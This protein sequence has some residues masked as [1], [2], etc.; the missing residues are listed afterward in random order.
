MFRTSLVTVLLIPALAGAK[1]WKPHPIHVVPG[2][3]LKADDIKPYVPPK[4][5]PEPTPEPSDVKVIE[6]V[7]PD[8]VVSIRPWSSPMVGT[9]GQGTRVP[10]RGTVK[11]VKGNGCAKLWYAL[12]PFGYI[13]NRDVKPTD[14][15]ASTEQVLKVREGTRLPF[16]YVMILVKDD[17]FMPMWA[18]LDDLKKGAEPER[19]LKKGDTVAVDKLYKWDGEDYWIAVDGKVIKKQ[20]ASLM[21]GGSSWH[22]IDITDQT[23][24][25]FGW[26]TPDKANVYDAP[27]DKGAKPLK[28]V[29]LERRTRVSIVGE[30]MVGKKLFL[31]VTVAAPPPPPTFGEIF[32]DAEK[33]R[34]AATA[35]TATAT[36]AAA[37]PPPAPPAEMWVSADAVNEVRVLEHPKTVP[38][39]M[40]RWI[41][42][43][44]GEQVLVLY[45]NDKPVWAT[46]TSS[47]RAIPTPM[48]TYPV[49][50]KVA[51]ITMKNQP[52]EDKPYYVNKV[53][54][55]TFFQWHNAIH[56]AYWHDRF[57]VTKSHGCVNVAPLDAKHVWEWVAPPMPPGWTG[58]RPLDL[59]VSAHVVVRNSHMKKQFRQDRPIGPPDKAL[60]SERLEEAE[61]RRAADAAAAAAGTPPGTP[62]APGTAPPQ[63]PSV[64]PP[65]SPGQEP[66]RP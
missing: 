36:D 41:D 50:A 47:G 62:G 16:Q 21:G 64:I 3:P 48:G 58:L 20:S 42:V 63:T 9:V 61:Q 18:S 40:P 15:P 60:E 46:L 12:E 17:T 35:A 37:A 24:L 52:Y 8:A 22:G 26:I 33:K 44:L 14:Q 6:V 56:G 11:P 57:G 31:K 30:Q 4:L 2:V 53:P 55:S 10:V 28:D 34:A 7:T 1:P 65:P 23:P 43:D 27:P 39:D 5:A 49:W 54:W 25:P 51:A 19:Q 66:P 59:L 38:A 13:C 45:E 32:A 29:T